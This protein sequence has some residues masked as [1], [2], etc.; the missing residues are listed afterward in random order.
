MIYLAT[1]IFDGNWIVH[2]F[3]N[4]NN[5]YCVHMNYNNISGNHIYEVSVN[6]GHIFDD[7]NT[8]SEFKYELPS[9]LRYIKYTGFRERVNILQDIVE[10]KI[11]DSI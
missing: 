9:E 5:L 11:L 8:T 2:E 3:I 6:D 1:Y 4:N 7:Y 10:Y